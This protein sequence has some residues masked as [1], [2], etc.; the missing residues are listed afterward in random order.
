MSYE[1]AA[2]I[3]REQSVTCATPEDQAAAA[4]LVERGWRTKAELAARKLDG[5]AARKAA[6][7]QERRAAE[8]AK[9]LDRIA[10]LVEERDAL[11][12]EAEAE[13]KVA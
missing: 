13:E 9:L 3:P 5:P 10:S 11:L 8:I 12:A 6:S 7:A 2:G 4:E 1:I